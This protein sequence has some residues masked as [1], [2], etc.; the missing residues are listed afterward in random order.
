MI[1]ELTHGGAI[2]VLERT[3]QFTGARHKVLTNNI[4]NL[5]TPHYKPKDLDP[6]QFQAQLRE[7]VE[8][9]R[10]GQGRPGQPLKMGQSEQLSYENGQLH[11]EPQRQNENIMF[12][13]RNNRNLERQMQNLAENT[14]MHRSSI[15]MLKNE[16]DL[17]N[18]AI[19][20]R[21]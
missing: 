18:T 12:H 4:A 13:D 10:E 1:A 17:V 6:E 9:R 11:P 2:P 15:R 20:M 19:R 5:S 16:F 7:A 14:M 21:V 8:A 3:V